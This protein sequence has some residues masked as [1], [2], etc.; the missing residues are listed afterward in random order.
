MKQLMQLVGISL[1]VGALL[2]LS[3]RLID[4]PPDKGKKDV[5]YVYNWGEYIDPDLTKKFEK[6]TGIKVVYETFDSNE[7]MMAKIKNG[8]TAYDVAVPSE[9]TVQ[10]MK[11]EKLLYPI[12]HNKIS[13]LKNIDK[14]F[15]NLPFDKGNKYSIPYFW[16]TVGILYNPNKTKGIDFSSWNSLW[17]KRLK[18]DVL[19]VD[20]AR[21]GV[22]FALNS[23]NESLNETNPNK[24]KKAQDKLVELA[25]NVRGVVGDE[26][27]TMM[28]QHE[29]DVAVVW[30]G[31]AADIMTE[32]P[33]LDF[34]VPEEGSNL[35]F[36]N[37]V[38]PKTAQNVEGAHKFINFLLDEEVGKQNAEW[39]G[40]AT[41]NK[42][43]YQLLDK[44][45]R[46]DERFYPDSKVRNKLEVYK[47]LGK[48]HIA[49]YNEAFLK[50]KMSLK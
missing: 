10:K 5:I 20:G 31:M 22:G 43:S 6:E 25:P 24:L 32:N 33:N 48:E 35:W 40:Y 34:V 16:G 4:P 45:V 49:E 17:D 37:L 46:E 26:I 50:F 13:N 3:T 11:K 2:M 27:N 29:S 1:I 14:D 19:V 18:D 41:P 39:V 42:A 47:D 28:V 23:M 38:I 15:M 36:D 7:A 44:D 21:E 12:D 9:Y 8:G 30:S